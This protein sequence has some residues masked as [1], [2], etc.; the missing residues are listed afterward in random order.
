MSKRPT[1]KKGTTPQPV[2]IS[3]N[4]ADAVDYLSVVALQAGLNKIAARLTHIRSSLLQVSSRPERASKGKRNDQD[5]S[6]N[7]NRRF[8]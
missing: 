1:D 8:N 4:M 3:R 5:K 7:E 6:Q 2:A